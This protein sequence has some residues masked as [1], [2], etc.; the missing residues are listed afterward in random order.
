MRLACVLVLMAIQATCLAQEHRPRVVVR[1]ECD[2]YVPPKHVQP[3]P[4]P[5]VGIYDADTN[6]PQFV[7]VSEEPVPLVPIESFITYPDEAKKNRIEG[8]V[9]VQALIAKDGH[10]EKADV[11]KADNNLFKQPAI[12]AMMK[13]KFSPAR[14]NGVPLRIW[15]TRTI[16]FKLR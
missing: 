5:G 2:T 15:V 10:V 13:T 6:S 12:D 8:K 3:T 1:S 9:V 7:D 16:N 4:G 11:L 14:Q